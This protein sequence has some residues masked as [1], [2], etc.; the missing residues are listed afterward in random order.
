[1]IILSLLIQDLFELNLLNGAVL[2]AGKN[3]VN[4]EITWVNIMEILDEMNN[5][6]KGELLLTTGYMLDNE[7]L[8]ENLIL[9][10]HLKGISGL[11]IQSGY[12]L[13][14]IPKY[15]IDAGNKY[16]FPIIEIP[17][18]LSFSSITQI[19]LEKV[20]NISFYSSL[21]KTKCL[22]QNLNIGKNP[23]SQEKLEIIQQLNL[24]VNSYLCIFL[25]SATSVHNSILPE[26]TILHI[27][28]QIYNYFNTQNISIISEN[29]NNKIIFLVSSS[30]NLS[31]QNLTIDLSKILAKLSEAL[32]NVIFLI[33]ASNIFNNI[34]HLL[35]SYEEACTS[36]ITLKEMKARKGICFYTYISLFKSLSLINSSEYTTKLLYQKIESLINYD[37]IHQ[38]SYLDTLKYFLDNG[39]NINVTSEKLYIHRHTLR[40]RLEKIKE[41]S[42]IDFNDNY[43][44]LSFSIAIFLY[45]FL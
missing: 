18:K 31:T 29:S 35:T 40:N 5:L 28:H 39:C 9:T 32:P 16:N 14:K 8:H 26:D 30:E 3:G 7:E 43:S 45:N 6:E 44:K 34:D 19:I 25:L 21:Q 42:H 27:I 38:S 4:H 13:S 12:Y 36:H 33:G 1:M 37:S 23:D 15:I 2:L 17:K 11:V 10:L 22:L 20:Y 24:N 41:L